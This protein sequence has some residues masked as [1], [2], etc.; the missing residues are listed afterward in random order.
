[1]L[2]QRNHFL[3]LKH[4]LLG[5]RQREQPDVTDEGA[6]GMGS[7]ER[8]FRWQRAVWLDHKINSQQHQSQGEQALREK[9]GTE[10]ITVQPAD[11]SSEQDTPLAAIKGLWLCTIR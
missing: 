2:E 1:M 3:T 6:P 5:N 7:G 11:A 10:L 8:S 4:V 9:T